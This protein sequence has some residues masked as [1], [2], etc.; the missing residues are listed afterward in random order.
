M[1]SLYTLLE[2]PYLGCLG[3]VM[4]KGFI[5]WSARQALCIR[6]FNP[7]SCQNIYM[8]YVSTVV[9]KTGIVATD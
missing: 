8:D 3:G 5:C 1:A 6:G 7:H 9:K 4:V 2:H